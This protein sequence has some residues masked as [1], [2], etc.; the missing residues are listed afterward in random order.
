VIAIGFGLV[1]LGYWTGLW[2]WCLLQ[3]YDITLWQLGSPLHPYGQGGQPWPP[4]PIGDTSVF[5][6][7]RAASGIGASVGQTI[8]Q[9]GQKLQQ[10]QGTGKGKGK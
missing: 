2:G 9:V 7:G 4:P 8:Q 10:Q 1:Y 6:S 3:G 5:P